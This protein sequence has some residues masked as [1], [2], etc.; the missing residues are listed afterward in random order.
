VIAS[1]DGTSSQETE[2]L[3]CAIVL[4]AGQGTRMQSSL[5]KVLH[6]VGART[7]IDWVLDALAEA[8]CVRRIVVVG[9]GR[10]QVEQEV[11]RTHP[12][13]ETIVQSEQLGTGDAV[14]VALA[15]VKP[16]EATVGVF[17][18]DTPLL[19]PETVRALQ[20]AHYRQRASATL[21][22]AH[23]AD[24]TG[25]GRVVR[26]RHGL[27]ERIVEERDADPAVRRLHEIN[28][29]AYL[30]QYGDLARLR[31]DNAQGEYYLTDTIAWLCARGRPVAAVT[32]EGDGVEVLG[33]NT[34]RQLR[35]AEKLLTARRTGR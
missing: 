32:A 26:D 6:R 33:V 14:R 34:P 17:S 7:M 22:T 20:R 24:P 28:A 8:G 30:Y 2:G 27:V 31:N 23:L 25:Y 11:M 18:G 3:P 5:P 12:E 4:A 10:R 15:R 1:G 13:A 19:R 9:F 21:L 29:G 16:A 35:L